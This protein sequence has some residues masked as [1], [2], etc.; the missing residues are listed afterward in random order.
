M[1]QSIC[2][3]IVAFAGLLGL[4]SQDVV[5]P[6][7]TRSASFEN[8]PPPERDALVALLDDRTLSARDLMASDDPL[9]RGV[10][11][12]LENSRGE[13]DT[14]LGA[15]D[16]LFDE[17]P[18]IPNGLNDPESLMFPP[19]ARRL[20]FEEQTVGEYLA[21]QY[22]A[23]LGIDNTMSREAMHRF[24]SDVGVESSLDRFASAW[25]RRFSIARTPDDRNTV[26]DQILQQPEQTRWA[27][28]VIMPYR[29]GRVESAS[30]ASRIA[31]TLSSATKLNASEGRLLPPPDPVWNTR[32][33]KMILMQD[34]KRLATP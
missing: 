12:F 5:P 13:I 1:S 27:V 31:N 14:L 22:R 20:I 8:F 32:D 34:S 33:A 4:S 2:V 26:L 19:D 29:A 15:R 7:V 17:R 10:G 28:A 21:S 3:L 6:A 9:E 23:W 25:I 18:T 24:V 11:I 30:A 16:L